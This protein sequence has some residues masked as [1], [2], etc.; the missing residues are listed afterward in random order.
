MEKIINKEHAL[1]GDI[2]EIFCLTT[3]TKTNH[4]GVIKIDYSK[5]TLYKTLCGLTK[6]L[7]LRKTKSILDKNE[8]PLCQTCNKS[9]KNIRNGN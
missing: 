7:N 3:N 5:M 2:R 9:L 4:A 6:G 8:Y 1:S